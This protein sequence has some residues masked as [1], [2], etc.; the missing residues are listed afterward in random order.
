MR[1]RFLSGLTQMPKSQIV[2]VDQTSDSPID[3]RN[4]WSIRT[5]I[6]YIH[7]TVQPGETKTWTIRYRFFAK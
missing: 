5:T 2:G 4:F 1:P 3:P 7:I 6:C